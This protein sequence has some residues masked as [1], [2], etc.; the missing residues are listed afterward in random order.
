MSYKLSR[1]KKYT[2]RRH[3]K[4]RHTKR[5]HTI[6][7][8]FFEK[9]NFIRPR[10]KIQNNEIMPTN[11]DYEDYDDEVDRRS[12]MDTLPP[13][14]DDDRIHKKWNSDFT[15]SSPKKGNDF[16]ESS[17]KKDDDDWND[18]NGNYTAGRRKIRRTRKQK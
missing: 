5:R 18:W 8:G 1:K 6:K 4:R 7:G 12:S 14:N 13:M 15:E 3:M 2:K 10:N 9:F 16:T 11:E 17:P